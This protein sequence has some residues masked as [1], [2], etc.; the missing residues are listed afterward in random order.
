[1]LQMSSYGGRLKYTVKFT[2]DG[3]LADRFHLADPDVILRVRK[4]PH[5]TWLC[6]VTTVYTW[7]K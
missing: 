7:N 3:S 5:C 2:L 1:M 6:R 4:T